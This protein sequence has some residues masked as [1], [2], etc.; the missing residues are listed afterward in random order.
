MLPLAAICCLGILCLLIAGTIVLALIPIYLPT[1]QI[2][3]VTNNSNG[4]I[5]IFFLFELKKNLGFL[6]SNIFYLEYSADANPATSQSGSLTN[7]DE[8][9]LKEFL[10]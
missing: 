4:T 1:R 3:T 9:E 7:T 2:N 5:S 6:D 10:I 8:V